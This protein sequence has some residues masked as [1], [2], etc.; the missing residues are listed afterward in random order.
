MDPAAE[1]PQARF[2]AKTLVDLEWTRL[3]GHLARRAASIEGAGRCLSLDFPEP[4]TARERLALVGEFQACIAAGDPPPALPARPVSEWLARVRGDADLPAEGLRDIAANLALAVALAR[5]LDNRRDICQR[6]IRALLAPPDAPPVSPVALARLAAEIEGCFDPDGNLADRAS[7]KLHTLRRRVISLRQT[8]LSRLDEIAERE[9]D[10][11][12][13]RS[14]T[15]RNDRFVLP[16]RADA[17]RRLGGIVHGTSGTGSTIFVEPEQSV[18]LGNELMLAREEVSREE[19]RI[20][21]EL[22]RAVGDQLDEVTWACRALI[23]ADLRSAAARMARDLDAAAPL[24]ATAGTIDLIDARHPLLLLEGVEVVPS[25]IALE[26][27]HCLL[28]SGPNAGGKTVVLKTVGLCGLMLAAGLPIPAAPESRFGPPSRVLTDIGDDQSLELSLSTFSARMRNIA[29]ILASARDGCLVLLDELAAGTDPSE[30]AALAEALLAH[31]GGLRATTL[32]TTHSDVLKSRA[33]DLAGFANAAMGF[34]PGQGRPTFQLR[35]G[36]PGSSSALVA[37]ERYG[38]PR[39]VVQR[40]RELLPEGLQR[41]SRVV[42]ALDVAR[43]ETELERLALGVQRQT[44]AA[45]EQRTRDELNRLRQRQDRFVDQE[46][47]TLHAAIRAAREKVRDAEQT[48]RRRGADPAV[49]R[50]ARD[51]IN[52]IAAGL[53]PGGP[54]SA[55]AVADL[56]GRPAAPGELIVGAR[57]WVPSLAAEAVIVSPARGA[58]VEVQAGAVRVRAVSAGLRLLDRTAPGHRPGTRGRVAAAVETAP[59]GDV[60]RT[61]ETTL[62]L[63]G[64]TV[65]EALAETEAFLDAA[66]GSGTE[67]VFVLHGHGTGALRDAVRRYL[68]GSRYVATHR[69]GQREEGGDGITVAW[70]R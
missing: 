64:R 26:A 65:D 35:P 22:R 56:P 39:A 47:A 24:A 40:A 66:L 41:L 12:Q 53:E 31:L 9:G 37:A 68:D 67:A 6:S 13:D 27:G 45:A 58:R 15:L 38:I 70:L 52:A 69:P 32:A 49:V 17:H 23:E 50:R 2:P 43:R 14:I 51:E 18:E 4:A 21:T 57:V 19:A 60:V 63:R 62:D 55:T 1:S 46:A 48:V 25:R 3:L 54:L 5:W 34:D 36:V 33:Q 61:S 11:L 30:G 20:L 28:I 8:L 42:E 16:V 29:G 59:R 7:P 44:L 10:L